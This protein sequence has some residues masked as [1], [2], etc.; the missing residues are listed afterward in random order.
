MKSLIIL[1]LLCLVTPAYSAVV[2]EVP[3]RGEGDSPFLNEGPYWADNESV[4]IKIDPSVN[5]S[6]TGPE[7]TFNV[8]YDNLDFS[9]ED[10]VQLPSQY[11]NGKKVANEGH[12]HLYATWLGDNSTD[13]SSP[14]FW[15]YTNLFVGASD[16]EVSPGVLQYTLNFPVN[17]EWLI[18]AESQYD[19]HTSRVR[20]HPQQI[21]AWDAAY[22]TVA[23]VIPEPLSYPV[24]AML[25]MCLILRRKR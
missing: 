20:P 8:Y 7:F 11:A 14:D 4:R 3:V 17:G 23:N 16:L 12:V 19:D 18:Y 21:G 10:A 2:T 15:N 13:P 6:F 1:L 24:L 9:P 5:G 25:G 22:V